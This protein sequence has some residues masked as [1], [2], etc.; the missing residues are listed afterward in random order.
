VV[1]A[2]RDVGFQHLA[3]VINRPP[4]IVCLAIDLDE[5]LVQRPLPVRVST[6][7]ANPVSSDLGGEHR[8]KSVP[9]EPDRFVADL[10]A[11]LM[12]EVLHVSKRKGK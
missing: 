11:A 3:F 1:P 4:Q 5:D 9:P 7:S 10:D 12:Q 6:N 8:A 2:L